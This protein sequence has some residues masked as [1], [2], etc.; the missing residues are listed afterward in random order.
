V[1]PDFAIKLEHL[2]EEVTTGQRR[3]EED[4]AWNKCIYRISKFLLSFPMAIP[5]WEPL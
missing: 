1:D 4:I 2:D 3:M 5:A